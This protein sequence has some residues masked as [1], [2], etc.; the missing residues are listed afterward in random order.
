MRVGR[1]VA[2]LSSREKPQTDNPELMRL[3]RGDSDSQALWLIEI[4]LGPWGFF[5]LSAS[6]SDLVIIALWLT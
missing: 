5:F 4:I 1:G 2:F 3:S 6:V